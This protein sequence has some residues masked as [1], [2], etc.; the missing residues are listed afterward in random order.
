VLTALSA[1][2][3]PSLLDTPPLPAESPF[4][5]TWGASH[6]SMAAA[7]VVSS[8]TSVGPSPRPQSQEASQPPPQQQAVDAAPA[9]AADD[10]RSTSPVHPEDTSIFSAAPSGNDWS[11]IGGGTDWSLNSSVENH[12]GATLASPPSGTVP[13]VTTV[14]AD[15]VGE[16]APSTK[17]SVAI[18]TEAMVVLR[19]AD[20]RHLVALGLKQQRQIAFGGQPRDASPPT[21]CSSLASSTATKAPAPLT[22]Q[23]RAGS[24]GATDEEGDSMSP[25]AKSLTALIAERGALLRIRRS[26]SLSPG[27]GH[28]N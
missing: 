11:K 28:E 8:T 26:D 14:T 12:L 6:A 10:D 25:A 17:R 15:V 3:V 9:A 1:A 20:A 19:E 13:K 18:G 22:P 4:A 23:R 2:S 16:A 21:A 24:V 7:A 5:A 27:R